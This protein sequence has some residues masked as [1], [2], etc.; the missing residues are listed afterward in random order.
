MRSGMPAEGAFRP[1]RFAGNKGAMGPDRIRAKRAIVR[2]ERAGAAGRRVAGVAAAARIVRDLAEAGVAEAWL[3]LPPGDRLDAAAMADLDR[4]SGPLDVRIADD[5]LEADADMERLAGDRLV[6]SAAAILKRTGKD[7]D[8]PVSR[9]LNRPVSRFISGL[10]LQMPGVRPIH[11]TIG[12]ALLA[13]SMFAALAFGG[14]TGLLV[15]GLLF[16]A[17]SVFDGVDGEIARATFRSSHSGAVLDSAVDVGTNLLFVIGITL[18]LGARSDLAL[19][20]AGWGFALF[21]LGLAAIAWRASRAAG[22]FS[23]DMVKHFYRRRFSGRLVPWLI[24]AMTIVSSRDFFALL[25]AA[26]ILAG[27]PMAVLTLFA[28]A[29]TV[30]ILF[31]LGSIRMPLE[32]PLAPERA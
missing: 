28:A 16:H 15:G 29:A 19:L 8:G 23:L 27:L 31:V 22:P 1:R 10:L 2:F 26:L 6:P 4:L 13:M 12:T 7:G 18:N 11:A 20:L 30:W 17:A 5:G 32:A 3:A 25:F 24:E 21:V 14:E 9:A